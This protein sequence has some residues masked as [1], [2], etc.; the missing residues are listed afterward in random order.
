MAALT[1]GVSKEVLKTCSTA[2]LRLPTAPYLG[3]NGTTFSISALL[4]LGA[5][6]PSFFVE[7]LLKPRLVIDLA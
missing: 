3:V 2:A 5:L 6:V 4:A 7:Y 1:S